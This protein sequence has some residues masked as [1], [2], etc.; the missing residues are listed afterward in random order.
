MEK[1]NRLKR[2]KWIPGFRYWGSFAAVCSLG[3][4]INQDTLVQS[5]ER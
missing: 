1:V 2:K 4:F 5:Y 3:Y